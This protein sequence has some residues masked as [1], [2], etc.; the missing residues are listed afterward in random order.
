ML[1]SRIIS[2]ILRLT[3]LVFA[4]VSSTPI[5]RF[6]KMKTASNNL[7]PLQIVAGIIGSYLDDYPAYQSTCPPSCFIYIQVISGISIIF[8]MLWS[9]P[10]PTT[11]SSIGR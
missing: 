8:A 10:S 9:L 4:T 7:N 1:L 5:V 6:K 3:K 11:L 2:L